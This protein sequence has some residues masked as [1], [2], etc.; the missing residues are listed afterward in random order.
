LHS[1]LP[2]NFFELPFFTPKK[3][4]P[5]HYFSIRVFPID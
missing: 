1:R 4:I 3:K 2:E 5:L